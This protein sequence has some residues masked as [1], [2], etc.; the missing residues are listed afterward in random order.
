MADPHDRVP[1]VDASAALE[2]QLEEFR[3]GFERLSLRGPCAEW[4]YWRGGGPGESVLWL[5]GAL[6]VGEFAF[7][8]ALA[9]A[10]RFRIVL[11][12]YP[13]VR[14]LQNLVMGLAELLDHEGVDTTHVVGGS[15]GGMLAQ[16]FARA[17]P[18][19][20]RS[21]VLSHT[22]A[23]NPSFVRAVLMRT[24]SLLLPERPYRA[25]F[26][27]RL[28]LA[29]LPAD[30]F[31]VSYFDAVVQRLDKAALA[32]RIRLANEFLQTALSP[33]RSVPRVL[34]AYSDGDPLMPASQLSELCRLYPKAEQ[35]RFSGTGHSAPL[36]RPDEYVAV[37]GQFLTGGKS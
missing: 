18:N 36:L 29:V 12:D 15:F 22:T 1:S 7:P 33:N 21:L 2:H 17:Y 3:S 30:P 19:R 25:L 28:R 24:I 6:G 26:R 5:T 8:Q 31:W 11:P 23:P 16:H 13:P 20:V 37:V 10:P 14:T 34:I 35:H 32:S 4:S 9:L 27:R